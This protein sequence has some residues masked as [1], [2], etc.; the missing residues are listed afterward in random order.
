MITRLTIL[1]MQAFLHRVNECAGAVYRVNGDG[2]RENLCTRPDLQAD[3]R[4]SH[5]AC[6][7]FPQLTLDIR[8]PKDY[9]HLVLFAIGGDNR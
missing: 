6:R 1:N 5:A 9:M 7:R 4:R 8:D 2:T 3:L